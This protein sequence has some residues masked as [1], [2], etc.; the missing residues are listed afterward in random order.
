MNLADRARDR[1]LGV[2]LFLGVVLSLLASEGGQGFG[3]DEGQYMR[4]GERYWGWFEEVAR[5]VGAGHPTRAFSAE[6]IDRFWSDN[7]PDHPVVM[8][9]LYGLSWRAFHR[10]TCTGPARG[11]HP[12]P[13][14]GRHITLTLFQR[15]STAFRFPAILMAGLL[16]WLVFRFAR[17]LVPAPAAV[18]AS[19][20]AIAQPHYFFH[21]PIACFDAPITTLAFAVGFAY[22]KS[23]R[24]RRWGLAAGVVFGIA[25]GVKHNAWLMPFFL[26]V[27][28]VWMRRGDL[29]R[30]RPPRVPLAFVSMALAGPVV[31]FLHWP[32]LWH[33]PVDRTRSY[34]RRHLEHEH[35][36]F[37][38]L[39]RNWNLPP[40]DG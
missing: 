6:T 9:T 12:I 33:H 31:F 14:R 37:E 13:V 35:Y 26:A 23:L 22:W 10:C 3:R 18:A 28:Y 20:L 30:L 38:Y 2:I 24:S 8:K 32:W 17:T 27:H 19:V 4:A 15:D 21:A 16:A 1:L 34:L 39:G 29:R 40:T 36:N 7:A 5:D 25:L 11:L